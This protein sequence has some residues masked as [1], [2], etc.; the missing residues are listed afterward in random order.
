MDNCGRT[1]FARLSF[2][3]LQRKPWESVFPDFGYYGLPRRCAAHNDK[4]FRK[5]CL[6]RS[7]LSPVGWGQIFLFFLL[8]NEENTA[9]LK[10]KFITRYKTD[11]KT[12]NQTEDMIRYI[13]REK[14]EVSLRQDRQQRTREEMKAAIMSAAAKNFVEKGYANSALREIAKDADVN[15]GSLLNIFGS[16]EEL[17]CEVVQAVLNKQF[18]VTEKLVRGKTSDKLM[19]YA[20]ETVLQL[21]IV[22]H[23]E[24]LRD[25]YAYAYALPNSSRFIQHTLTEKLEVIFKE[26]LPHLQTRD[27][28]KLEIASGGIM[29]GFMTVPCDMWFTMDQKV[30][31]FLETTFLIYEVPKSKIEEAIEFVKQFD[32]ETIAEQ[33]I[34]EIVKAFETAAKG[35]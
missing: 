11:A 18:E 9:I 32:F 1:V 28:Y 8:T 6:H 26:H 7:D 24:N 2:R 29:R 10:M 20:A 31:S 3:G 12:R 4:V 25:V 34:E 33:A 27:F 30:R 13:T 19:F 21:H 23:S 15:I 14:G 22:E 5:V 16:K 17:L 35:A